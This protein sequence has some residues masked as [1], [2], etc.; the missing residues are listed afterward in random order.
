MT[1][2]SFVTGVRISSHGNKHSMTPTNFILVT[3]IM[4]KTIEE[5][6]T[7]FIIIEV[8]GRNGQRRRRWGK[9]RRFWAAGEAREMVEWRNLKRKET[10]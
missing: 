1:S 10:E 7:I 9:K 5:R 6:D 8:W 3:Q 4:P 2:E